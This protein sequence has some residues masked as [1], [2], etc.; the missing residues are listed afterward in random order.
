MT[1]RR[2]GAGFFYHNLTCQW[3]EFSVLNDVLMGEKGVASAA[4][5]GGHAGLPRSQL[6]GRCVG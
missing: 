3:S 5:L 2:V 6:E 4:C 1:E